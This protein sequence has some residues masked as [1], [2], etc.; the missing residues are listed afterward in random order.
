MTYRIRG[1][2]PCISGKQGKARRNDSRRGIIR[3]RG[4]RK[5]S[6]HSSGVSRKTERDETSERT[7]E[8]TKK[9]KN[10]MKS[11]TFSR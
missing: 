4:K 10:S 8:S 7:R 6:T 9:D 3:E 11:S 1:K 5:R 2:K